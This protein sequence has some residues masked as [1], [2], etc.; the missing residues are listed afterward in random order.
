PAI[1][2]KE[3]PRRV[4]EEESQM[5]RSVYGSHM[6]NEVA[7]RLAYHPRMVEPAMQILGSK[8]YIY[9]FKINAKAAFGG[10]RW[11]WHQDYIFW[12]KEDGM[13]TP[14][15]VNA[16]IFLDEVNEFNGP[17]LFIPGS[18][19][20]GVIDVAAQ[21]ARSSRYQQSPAWISNLTASLKYALD[22]SVIA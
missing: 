13:H 2:A 14:R 4:L 9:Q 16:V 3:S 22:Q 12:Q 15:V 5:V 1:F 17:L 6:T 10:D 18:H 21:D 8:V 20:E 11:E 7:R 19:K